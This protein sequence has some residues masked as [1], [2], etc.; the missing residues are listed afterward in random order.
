MLKLIPTFSRKK[1]TSY[2][3]Q[4]VW[5]PTT[6]YKATTWAAVSFFYTAAITKI[7]YYYF[8]NNYIIILLIFIIQLL[9]STQT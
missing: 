7:S 5:L 8:Y 4:C 3:L 2:A 6:H 9:A 1:G